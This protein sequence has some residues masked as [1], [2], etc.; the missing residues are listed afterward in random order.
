MIQLIDKKN[1]VGCGNCAIVC[2]KN[3]ITMQADKE[4]FLY[5]T[6]ST[7]NCIDCHLC[8]KA[9]PVLQ[10]IALPHTSEWF[11]AYHLQEEI[12]L[13]SSSGGIFYE[14]AKLVLQNEDGFVWGAAFVSPYK[15]KH[16]A[17]K[18]IEDLHKLQK[19][20]YVQSDVTQSFPHVKRQLQQSKQVLFSGTPCQ[21]KALRLYLK[22]EYENLI[23]IEVVCH[24]VPA[25]LVLEQ[26]MKVHDIINIDFRKKERG[27]YNYDIYLTFAN[28]RTK[29]MRAVDNL[30][31][32]GFLHGLYNRPSCTACPAKSGKS[33]ADITLG[34]LWGVERFASDLYNNQGVSLIGLHTS[35]ARKVWQAIRHLYIARKID[36]QEALAG[37]PCLEK[38][39]VSSPQ[40]K[41]FFLMFQEKGIQMALRQ[42]ARK[43]V[44]FP[45]RMKKY[46]L[47]V[48]SLIWNIA[49][50]VREQGYLMMDK[51]YTLFHPAPKVI[52]IE[53]TLKTILEKRCSVSR[54]GDGELKF[55]AG[56]ETWFQKKDA[57][58]QKGLIRVLQNEQPNLMV[59]I[60]PIFG[61]LQPLTQQD[62][63][64]WQSHIARTRKTWYRH[65]NRGTT[66][67]DAFISRCYMPY[68]DKSHTK[69]YFDLWKQIWADRDLLIIEGEKTRLGIGN[70]LFDNVR[71]IKR[72][73]C[74]NTQAFQYYWQLLEEALK[75][76]THHLILLAIGP[77]AT[78]LAADLSTQGY[79]AIDIGHVDIEYEWYR[80]GATHKVPVFGKFVNEAGA[81]VGVDDIHDEKYKKEIVCRF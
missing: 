80:M 11:G 45:Q 49:L 28:H 67:Y 36:Y 22:Q 9:C 25:P 78:L 39:S 65:L 56:I 40:R 73:L 5:P 48:W 27:W 26:Y 33:N 66:Y 12:R 14:L 38:S 19:S 31:M 61:S 15:V 30:Y 60:P 6:I 62:R 17:I 53:E 34:D 75:Y 21:I 23:T 18:Q 10:E 32:K 42:Y 43:K 41:E 59:C 50:A 8:E 4:G 52:S 77:T 47:V 79:Q 54:L 1:C 70:D 20:K 46:L 16:I 29:Q 68:Q 63:T 3:C 13:N 7:Q 58:L 74:P 44:S 37:N 71:S 57:A 64:Y 76:D 69:Q 55:I 51:F 81:G 35:K 24:G 2:P 72:I